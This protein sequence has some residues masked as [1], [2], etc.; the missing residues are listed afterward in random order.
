MR[1]ENRRIKEWEDRFDQE[2]KIK[3]DE[4]INKFYNNETTIIN[5]NKIVESFE[6]DSNNSDENE[7]K[8]S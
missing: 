7:N 2:H 6:E 1:E 4:L 5:N 8:N 3:E